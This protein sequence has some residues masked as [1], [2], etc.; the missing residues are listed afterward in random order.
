MKSNKK[1]IQITQGFSGKKTQDKIETESTISTQD[2][3]ILS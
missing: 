1:K 3:S 2:K